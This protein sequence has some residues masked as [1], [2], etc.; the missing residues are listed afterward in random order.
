MVLHALSRNLVVE[1]HMLLVMK[2][3]CWQQVLHLRSL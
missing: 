3:R 2:I 1:L